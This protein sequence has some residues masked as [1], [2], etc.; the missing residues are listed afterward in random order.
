MIPQ[1]PITENRAKEI[2]AARLS[3][4]AVR[5]DRMFAI[6]M[7]LQW[8]AAIVFAVTITPFSWSGSVN[9]VHVHVYAAIFLGGILTVLPV[10]LAWKQPGKKANR[11]VIAIAQMCYSALLVHLTGGRIETHFHIFGSL[12]F[13]AIYRDPKVLITATIATGTDHFLRG[14]FWPASVYGTFSATYWRA[15]EH[16]AW[17]IFEDIFLI[18]SIQQGLDQTRLSSL[19][20]AQLEETLRTVEERVRERTAELRASNEIIEAQQQTMVASAKNSAL[21]EMAGQIAH[22]INTPLGAIVLTAQG[23][24]RK[25]EASSVD[26]SEV[27]QKMDFILQITNKL[28]RIIGSMRKLAGHGANEQMA[29]TPVQTILEDVLLLCEGRFRKNGIQF[30]LNNRL[31]ERESAQCRANE[32]SQVLINLLNNAHDAVSHLSDRWISL[33]VDRV[34][35]F[36]RFRVIDSGTKIPEEIRKKLFTPKFSTKTLDQGTGFG[37]SISKRLVEHHQGHIYLDIG[38]NTTFT[39]EIPAEQTEAIARAAH[40]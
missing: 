15:V 38:P 32:I 20:Q 29:D 14:A 23:L 17:V 21:G 19:Q 37:L 33:D 6:L 39:V 9:S 28:S 22:E 24:M 1:K 16:S 31:G 2:C 3:S 36:L 27:R 35:R 13:L 12:A 8:A 34:G 4:L 10:Y 30:T 7:L 25:A 26:S 11:H 18:Y 5:T 40:G